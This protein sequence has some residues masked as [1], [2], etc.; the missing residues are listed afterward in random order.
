MGAYGTPVVPQGTTVV[1]APTQQAQ[2]MAVNM[3]AAAPA[4]PAPQPVSA[5]APVEPVP[6]APPAVESQPAP[7]ALEG[8]GT[9]WNKPAAEEDTGSVGDEFM[10]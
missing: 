10:S 8:E 3:S 2:P 4:Q 5:P 1:Q 7:Q 6:V 9:F